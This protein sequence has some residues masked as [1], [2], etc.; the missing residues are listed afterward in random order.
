M[1]AR[2]SHQ[3]GGVSK[4]KWVYQ[5]SIARVV[6]GTDISRYDRKI[7]RFIFENLVAISAMTQRMKSLEQADEPHPTAQEFLAYQENRPSR[8]EEGIE[9]VRQRH[10][11]EASADDRTDIAHVED[12]VVQGKGRGIPVR[13]YSNDPTGAEP[14]LLWAHG[15][16]FVF[17]SV[18]TEDA[19]ARILASALECTIVS[20]DYRLAPEHPFPAAL[21][22]VYATLRWAEETDHKLLQDDTP[23]LVGGQSAGANIAAAGTLLSQYR[24]GPSIDRQVLVVP[25]LAYATGRNDPAEDSWVNQHYLRDPIDGYN[26]L[27]Y[28]LEA[29]SLESLPPATIVTAGYDDNRVDGGAYGGRLLEA[30]VEVSHHHYPDTVHHFLAFAGDSDWPRTDAAIEAIRSDIHD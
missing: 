17:G 9:P 11:A 21:Q 10:R 22:D 16:G 5:R 6:A 7:P 25:V 20:V 26:Q 12:V 3:N 2:P 14:A 15:G 29:N 30:G 28:P 13:L 4:R 23:T 8:D 19:T 18:H 1:D 24:T 27:A